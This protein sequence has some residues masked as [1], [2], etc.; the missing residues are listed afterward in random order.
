MAPLS[1]AAYRLY[2]G[3]LCYCN[4]YGL[5][6]RLTPAHVATLV[7][8]G[9]QRRTHLARELVDATLWTEEDWGWQIHDYLLYQ[10]DPTKQAAGRAGGQASAQAR[11]QA[12]GKQP[13]SVLLK[14]VLKPRTRPVPVGDKARLGDSLPPT[15][16][17]STEGVENGAKALTRKK[18]VVV[19][20]ESTGRRG[21]EAETT[22]E[23]LNRFSFRETHG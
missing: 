2:V 17:V 4:R 23:I 11:A 3:A 13:A 18:A 20:L 8:A 1:D 10:P 22:G 5:G 14:H 12:E 15:P 21:G 16:L 9:A 6:G 19:T 7:G